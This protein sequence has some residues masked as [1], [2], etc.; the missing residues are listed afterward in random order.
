MALALA[1]TDR[2]TQSM[3]RSSSMMAPLIRVMAYVS[4]LMARSVVELLDGVDEAE[5]PVAHQVRL[6]DRVRQADGN[7]AGDVLDQGRVADDQLVPQLSRAGPSCTRPTVPRWKSL[8]FCFH[9][10]PSPSGCIAAAGHPGLVAG[11]DVCPVETFSPKGDRAKATGGNPLSIRSAPIRPSGERRRTRPG[12]VPCSRACRSWVVLTLAWPS[13]SCTTL[14]SA[15]PS[16]M[17]VAKLC[18]R[19]CGW[20]GDGDRRSRMR[21]TSRGPGVGRC[22]F[23]KRASAG[24]PAFAI[25]GRPSLQPPPQCAG[26]VLGNGHSPL[27]GPFAPNGRPL[28]PPGRR[29]PSR[30]RT[31]R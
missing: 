9:Q 26:G 24:D 13:S 18:R 11:Q 2:G 14:R 4:N 8:R 12:D 28:A 15:P 19:A 3:L 22:E 25:A 29:R 10:V 30:A 16:S 5:N 20:V 27:L 21:R 17:W 1:R 6:L 7:P 31:A 23:R